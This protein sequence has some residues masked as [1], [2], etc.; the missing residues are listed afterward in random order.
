MNP[1]G[2][3]QAFEREITIHKWILQS[4]SSANSKLPEKTFSLWSSEALHL[5]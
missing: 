2:K 5:A 3:V 1:T 4:R